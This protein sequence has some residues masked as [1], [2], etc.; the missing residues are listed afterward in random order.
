[1][2]VKHCYI[3][4]CPNFAFV[5]ISRYHTADLADGPPDLQ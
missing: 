3:T 5:E 1:M 2:K 4:Q